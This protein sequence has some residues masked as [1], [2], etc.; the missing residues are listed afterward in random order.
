LSAFTGEPDD[1]VTHFH[2]YFSL[3]Q[4][5]ADWILRLSRLACKGWGLQ[6]RSNFRATLGY[7]DFMAAVMVIVRSSPMAP[8]EVTSSLG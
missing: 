3:G 4:Y 8:F 1:E 6:R 7:K 5:R 2:V